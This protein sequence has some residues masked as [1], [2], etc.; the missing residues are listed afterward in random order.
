MKNLPALIILLFL[1]LL[2]ILIYG[3]GYFN[4]NIDLLNKYATF[5]SPIITLMLGISG[6][7]LGL[8]Y[9]KSRKNFDKQNIEKEKI[10]FRIETL[11]ENINEYDSL[12]DEIFSLNFSGQS[13]LNSLREKIE[14]GFEIIEVWIEIGDKFFGF[15]K[16]EM[17]SLIKFHS[18]VDNNEFIMEKGYD[19]LMASQ[20]EVLL[21]KSDYIK[22]IQMARYTCLNKIV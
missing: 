6:F 1:I 10:R 16:N 22:L 2:A 18:F 11:L 7:V 8:Y 9:Y 19:E 17:A 15:T 3:C 20:K 13:E 12:V 5:F 21:L 14:R 4:K